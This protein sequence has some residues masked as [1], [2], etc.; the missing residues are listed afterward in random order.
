[1]V[2]ETGS[3]RGTK[4]RQPALEVSQRWDVLEAPIGMRLDDDPP[5]VPRKRLLRLHADRCTNAF[6]ESEE[7][8]RELLFDPGAT[9][10]TGMRS[11]RNGKFRDSAI[12]EVLLQ[13]GRQ[14]PNHCPTQ[15]VTTHARL[16][17]ES[18]ALLPARG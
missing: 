7:R 14:L 12:A 8:L 10:L 2:V 13:P 16:V 9:A 6:L 18:P 5:H 17:A 15:V 3:R 1:M 4:V 11:V